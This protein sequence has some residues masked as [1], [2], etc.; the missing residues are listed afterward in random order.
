MSKK[1]KRKKQLKKNQQQYGYNY[2]NPNN[3]L[4]ASLQSILPS[5]QS[6]QF[7]MG[8]LLGAAATYVLSDEE[9]RARLMKGGVKL[10]SNI[11][12]SFEE[13]KEQLA[14]VRAELE[15]EQQVAE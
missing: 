8:L 1:S 4:F 5:H 7:L 12:G 9:I 6:D 10:F 2:G 14:D 11:A 15:A 13:M 3:G